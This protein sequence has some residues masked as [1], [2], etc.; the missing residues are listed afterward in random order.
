MPVGFSD[1]VV[2]YLAL[3]AAPFDPGLLFES[4]GSN[5]RSRGQVSGPTSVAKVWLSSVGSRL[6]VRYTSM[7]SLFHRA[8]GASARR[9]ITTET[10]LKQE[11]NKAAVNIDDLC[12][13]SAKWQGNSENSARS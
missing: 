11:W 9:D 13:R 5:G 4:S 1:A 7:S 10:A 8:S 3:D 6:V 12:C 2:P